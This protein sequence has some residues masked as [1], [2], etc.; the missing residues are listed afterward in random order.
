MLGG[1]AGKSLPGFSLPSPRALDS[2]ML[3]SAL[4]CPAL[5]GLQR[6]CLAVYLTAHQVPQFPLKWNHFP[7]CCGLWLPVSLGLCSLDRGV[8]G[9]LLLLSFLELRWEKGC[10]QP[11][12]LSALKCGI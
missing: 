2:T 6:K 9:V 11:P 12:P 4:L 7:P 8:G 5:R 10:L 1:G 3:F